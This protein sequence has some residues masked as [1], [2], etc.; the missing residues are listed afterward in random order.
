MGLPR[1]DSGGV[2]ARQDN[3]DEL[4]CLPEG[5][6]VVPR[7]CG[8][9]VK[10]PSEPLTAGA[11]QDWLVAAVRSGPDLTFRGTPEPAGEGPDAPAGEARGEPTG[12]VDRAGSRKN[13]RHAQV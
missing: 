8:L 4:A 3:G 10:Q 12:C 11:V 2:L 5:A 6:E 13:Y 1:D 9:T 7:A